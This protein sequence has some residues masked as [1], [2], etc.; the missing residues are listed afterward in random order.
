MPHWRNAPG[1]IQPG[2]MQHFIIRNLAKR[3]YPYKRTCLTGLNYLKF[4]YF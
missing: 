1:E 4:I 3:N 2:K